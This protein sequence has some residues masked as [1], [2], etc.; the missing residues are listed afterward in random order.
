MKSKGRSPGQRASSLMR[1]RVDLEVARDSCLVV[2]KDCHMEDIKVLLV[3]IS[4]LL[5]EEVFSILL[6][7]VLRVVFDE[8]LITQS[9]TSSERC[10]KSY[11]RGSRD[12][13]HKALLWICIHCGR[14]HYDAC[15]DGSKTCTSMARSVTISRLPT[16]YC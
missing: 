3:E 15:R 5:L 1:F 7:Q 12:Q 6:T 2:L 8:V 9:Q 13:P 11:L 16:D 10:S 14:R 4:R